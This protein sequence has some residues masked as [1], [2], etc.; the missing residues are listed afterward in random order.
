[1]AVVYTCKRYHKKRTNITI[2]LF[3]PLCLNVWA[4]PISSLVQ[5]EPEE[6]KRKKQTLLIDSGS[7]H[8]ARANPMIDKTCAIWWATPNLQD[9]SCRK[10]TRYQHWSVGTP[11]P[12]SLNHSPIKC[13]VDF[14]SCQLLQRQWLRL[15][16][17]PV[18][19]DKS[20][21]LQRCKTSYLYTSETSEFPQT[22]EITGYRGP[23]KP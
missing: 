20:S 17:T 9:F 22:V 19:Q 23:F 6:R 8:T 15:Q 16:T 14:F 3:L 5:K 2:F 4:S 12:K 10:K 11:P 18:Q 13:L 7:H 21:L 1:M